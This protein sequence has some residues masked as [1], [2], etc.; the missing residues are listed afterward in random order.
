MKK[1]IGILVIAVAIMLIAGACS[2]NNNGTQS[3][4]EE[5]GALMSD[6]FNGIWEGDIQVPNAPLKVVLHFDETTKAMSV[7]SQNVTKQPFTKA[8]FK[9]QKAVLTMNLGQSV[10][11][12]EGELKGDVFSGTYEQNGGSYP[13]SVTKSA[14]VKDEHITTVTIDNGMKV[15]LEMPTNADT[16]PVVI[17]IAGSGPTNKDGNSNS[18]KMLS[19]QL[20]EKGIA[21]VRF[22]K[23]GLGDNAALIAHEKDL[24]IDMLI[25]DV[26]S[27]IQFM[28][29]D[30]RFTSVSIIGHS[31]G[32]LIGMVAA[33]KEEVTKFVSLAGMGNSA[34]SLLLEQ[35][36][37]QLTP[38]LQKEANTIIQQMKEGKQTATVPNELLTLFRPS[39]QP[40][41]ISLFAY[42]PAEII[43][44]LNMPVLIVNGT[45]DIQVSVQEANRLK[46]AK[47]DAELF[48]IEGMNHILKQAPADREG[49]LATYV[50]E[51]LPIDKELAEKVSA[52]LKE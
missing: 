2:N 49:N 10:A 16:M 50:D 47:A 52:F 20:L 3:Y 13:F 30:K 41:L 26:I 42:D 31:E 28:K 37:G 51:S 8:E 27:M 12:F 32:S 11:K 39:V 15:A 4:E 25:E 34:D 21:T 23:R 7:P 9:D 48:I 19:Q 40:Y 17:I 5:T 43:K 35:L 46:E 1:W 36:Q 45:H 29:Q 6:E 44:T 33:Q 38:E 24:T 14:E 18:L 22:D